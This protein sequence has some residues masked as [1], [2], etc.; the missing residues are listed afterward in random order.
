LPGYIVR[1]LKFVV[2]LHRELGG[3][4]KLFSDLLHK[5]YPSSNDMKVIK[6]RRMR[7]A[8]HVALTETRNA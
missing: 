7:W 2:G 5:L 1:K 8:R 3:C 4:G 6:S